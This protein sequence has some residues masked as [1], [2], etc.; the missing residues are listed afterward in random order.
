MLPI[1]YLYYLFFYKHTLSTHTHSHLTRL[2]Y[3][4]EHDKFNKLFKKFKIWK[5]FRHHEKKTFHCFL[6]TVGNIKK[7]TNDS[8]PTLFLNSSIYYSFN[9]KITL[10]F[11]TTGKPLSKTKL[12]RKMK[13]KSKKKFKLPSKTTFHIK[14][15]VLQHTIH[16]THPTHIFL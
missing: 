5:F 12:L 11:S 7:N 13:K 15:C 16:T 1:P 9:V 8:V 10:K 14:K 3:F 2:F 4:L 6:N